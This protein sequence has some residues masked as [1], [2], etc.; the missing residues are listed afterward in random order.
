MPRRAGPPARAVKSRLASL[1]LT[2]A[3]FDAQRPERA[4]TAFARV[5][6]RRR[7]AA[8]AQVAVDALAG[9]GVVVEARAEDD[10]HGQRMH[11]VA[12]GRSE[13]SA[14][15]RLVVGVDASG[16]RVGVE[17]PFEARGDAAK[18]CDGGEWLGQP[19]ETAERDGRT[20]WMGW[21]VPR[22]AAVA[23][24]R[25]FDGR[26]ADAIAALGPVLRLVA[27]P[28]DEG[29]ARSHGK[30]ARRRRNDRD[31]GH[32]DDRAAHAR[33]KGRPYDRDRDREP[34]LVDDDRETVQ[35]DLD[36]S[37]EAPAKIHRLPIGKS[38]LR[39]A[40]RGGSLGARVDPRA[41]VDKGARVRVLDGPFCGKVGVVQE[42]D[43]KGTA[44]VML[45]LL[46]VRLDVKDLAACAEGRDRPLLSS[47]HR[48]PMPV[49][50]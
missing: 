37:R 15:P 8:W 18:V 7:M 9:A 11:L 6:L 41:P 13:D 35:P 3:D 31:R 42:I 36:D 1:A 17:L 33:R 24:G 19:F 43:G 10:A 48:K 25:L 29:S 26:L 2:D 40:A 12:R 30:G 38:P 21:S 4:A 14:Q 34:A 22:E 28:H 49:R 50:S 5:D 45:G 44:R 20:L 46:A 32:D 27:W 47:S 23:H 39:A 16:V